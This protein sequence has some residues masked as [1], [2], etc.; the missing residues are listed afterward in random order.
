MSYKNENNKKI[1]YCSKH[2]LLFDILIYVFF[3]LTQSY[4]LSLFACLLCVSIHS[5]NGDEI[6][7]I[8]YMYIH[9]DT[10]P[11]KREPNTFFFTSQW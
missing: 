4:F 1:Q 6:F 5:F 9:G 10:R 11:E 2:F 8:C 7:V 3:S